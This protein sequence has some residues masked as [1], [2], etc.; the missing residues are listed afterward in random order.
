MTRHGMTRQLT[1]RDTD[2]RLINTTHDGQRTAAM[3]GRFTRILASAL[4]IAALAAAPARA[5]APARPQTAAPL[6][7]DSAAGPASGVRTGFLHFD[8]GTQTGAPAFTSHVSYPLNGETASFDARYA[9]KASYVLAGRLGFRVGRNIALGVAFTHYDRDAS[10]G[11]T[12]QLPHPIRFATNRI[13]SGTVDGLAR[14]ETMLAAEF[15]WVLKLG[16]RADLMI[17]AGPA[18]FS[19]HQDMATRVQYT[20]TVPFDVASFLGAD[21]VTVRQTG[22]GA[23]AGLD[24]SVM[25]SQSVGI[26]S[27]LRY[28]WAPATLAAIP[29]SSAKVLLGGAQGTVGLR[30]R[31]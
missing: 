15:S 30:V 4:V 17:F 23:T 18:F 28:S 9:S 14:K 8:V 1:H 3:T 22:V 7:A 25:F 19:T 2:T 6:A 16:N 13:V 27:V 26:G 11:I 21:R 5:Q 12:A 29:G 31:F 10:A 20:E 24:I